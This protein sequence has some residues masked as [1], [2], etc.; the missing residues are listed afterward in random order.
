M[1]EYTQY[2]TRAAS[3]VVVSPDRS[4][5]GFECANVLSET[6]NDKNPRYDWQNK[7]VLSLTVEE[8]GKFLLLFDGKMPSVKLFHESSAG[9]KTLNLQM[10]DNGNVLVRADF[11]PNEG[12][13]IGV[14]GMSLSQPDQVVIAELLKNGIYA[15][16]YVERNS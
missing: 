12:E 15:L 4:F 3:R 1:Y 13:K 6:M 10:A 16:T 8:I 2:R 14:S 9:K 5:V 11:S 7:I